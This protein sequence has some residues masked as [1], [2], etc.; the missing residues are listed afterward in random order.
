MSSTVAESAA[1][2]I[3]SPTASGSTSLFA[4]RPWLV[5][6]V[7][8][9]VGGAVYA[10]SLRG[11]FVLDDLL[12]IVENPTIESVSETLSRIREM[13]RPTVMV[14]IACNYQISGR[15]PWSYHVV[16]IAIHIGNACLIFALLR[17]MFA[18]GRMAER[19]RSRAEA[20][21]FAVALLWLVH[22]LCTQ[23]V[24]YVIQR[25]ESLMG[26]FLLLTLYCVWRGTE[27]SRAWYGAAFLACALGM[28]CKEVMV[29]AP[30]LALLM[31]RIYISNS[32]KETLGRRWLLHASL[33]AAWLVL[34][35][36]ILEGFF[37]ASGG[38]TLSPEVLQ[39]PAESDS[40]FPTPSP[41]AY[42]R[43]QPG[44]LLHYLRLAIVPHPLTFDY[45]W[46]EAS[47]SEAIVPAFVLMALAGLTFW[48]L[49]KYPG[50]GFWGAWFFLILAPSSSIV[51]IY[52][53]AVEHRMYLPLIGVAL[54]VVS[55][56]DWAAKKLGDRVELAL[57]G[58]ATAVLGLLTV[59]R[60][61]DYQDNLRLWQTVVERAPNNP[62]GHNNLGAYLRR[63]GKTEEAEQEYRKAIALMPRYPS[64]L[65]NLG[66]ALE[67]QGKL[68]DAEEQYRAS[69][70]I[71][72]S[73]F[74]TN[75]GLS[76]VLLAQGRPDEALTAL[77]AAEKMRPSDPDLLFNKAGMLRAKGK[78][79]E[80]ITLYEKLRDASPNQ[81]DVRSQL[82]MTYL[83]VG[84]GDD[85]VRECRKAAE[86]APKNLLF[87]VNLGVVQ[88]ELGL[89]FDAQD[90]CRGLSALEPNW[91]DQVNQ[92]ARNMATGRNAR[93][94]PPR[95][96]K[97]ARLAAF[98]TNNH[99]EI[100]DTLALAQSEA[101]RF[102]DAAATA[103][104]A[105]D[106][107]NANGNASLAQEI[108]ARLERYK[109]GQKAPPEPSRN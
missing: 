83:D 86:L 42:A 104:R 46:P 82:G 106:A 71:L 70:K 74:D 77:K 101:G 5:P 43:S 56:A 95:A 68:A 32:W 96:T 9:L 13:G 50:W 14:T 97:L 24:T 75:L 92:L 51:P 80:A 73:A 22:P 10:N 64:A 65:T 15:D 55:A 100:L 76:T 19:G 87:R 105:V 23:A 102:D 8:L 11:V 37:L 35:R 59:A 39:A 79:N 44:V 47:V 53:L 41:I 3:S 61:E 48:A 109:Q 91:V 72:P 98:A 78:T 1:P 34:F 52:D 99:P 25:C 60:N 62:R 69:L 38:A 21:A 103:Q 88:N 31:D 45:M 57:L 90:T 93:P 49:A 26:F 54:L 94:D 108:R 36:T 63:R 29:V 12:H 58:A 4:S 33:A 16:N 17:R 20:L 30:L 85:A 28:G 18:T 7:F 27:G 40:W 107:A 89:L 66:V 81:A 84:R 6:L 67:T 2:P